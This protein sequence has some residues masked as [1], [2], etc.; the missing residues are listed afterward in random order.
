[1]SLARLSR[2]LTRHSDHS[3]T[4]LRCLGGHSA[5]IRAL[6]TAGPLSDTE[7]SPA[8]SP[9]VDTQ[10]LSQ[11]KWPERGGQDLSQ[12][13]DRLER[14][15]RGKTEIGRH[16]LDLLE[17]QHQSSQEQAP[18]TE[19]EHTLQTSTNVGRKQQR[20]FK[21][22]VIPDPPKPPADDECCMSGCA[23]CVYDLYDEARHDY[24]QAVDNI[25]ANLDKMG[26]PEDEWPPDIRRKQPPPEP[27]A[28]P[29]VILSAF[30]QLEKQ[31]R[32]KKERER[33]E[34]IAQGGEGAT[35]RVEGQYTA[36]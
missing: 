31:L 1:M 11:L 14:A 17:Q 33:R 10:Q 5:S 3:V 32:E 22:F 27:S 2:P 4:L 21:G 6:T 19:E 34:A 12:R 23:V 7:D 36:S 16:I 18:Y 15:V 26:V 20:I 30:E 28:R 13:H 29:D 9:P 8:V 35:N 24:I 25:R